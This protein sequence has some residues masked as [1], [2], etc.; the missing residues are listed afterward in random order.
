MCKR[1]QLVNY[2]RQMSGFW[3]RLKE[4]RARRRGAK[5]ER[6]VGGGSLDANRQARRLVWP[7]IP[8]AGID[9]V[10]QSRGPR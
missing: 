4:R 1:G 2:D 6:E 7:V 8:S 5:L 3:S 9:S 10:K